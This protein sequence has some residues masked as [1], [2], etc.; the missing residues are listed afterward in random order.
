MRLL[1]SLV[2]TSGLEPPTPCMS[3]KYSNQLSYA[4]IKPLFITLPSYSTACR[5]FHKSTCTADL[6][7]NMIHYLFFFVNSFE[8]KNSRPISKNGRLFALI[9]TVHRTLAYPISEERTLTNS[10]S[11]KPSPMI[12]K[13]TLLNM[14]CA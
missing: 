3:S 11:L 2:R 12:L 4:L 6:T 13:P 10:F 9:K 7:F 5:I 1:F 14:N 8:R